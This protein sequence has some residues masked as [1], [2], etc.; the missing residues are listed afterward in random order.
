MP[1]GSVVFSCPAVSEMNTE[2]K[3]CLQKLT[4]YRHVVLP[5]AAIANYHRLN[6]QKGV[7]T[8]FWRLEIQNEG[9]SWAV[10]P[11]SHW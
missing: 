1:S 4:D 11:L 9:V 5:R 7:L 2:G 10:H 6:Q 3:K 8:Q